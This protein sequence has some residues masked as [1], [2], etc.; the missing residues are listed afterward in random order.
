[1]PEIQVTQSAIEKALANANAATENLTALQTKRNRL[2]TSIATLEAYFDTGACKWKNGGRYTGRPKS[3][4]HDPTSAAAGDCG[5]K[6]NQ[7]F[8][9][10][11]Q[12][13]VIGGQI[14]T[15]EAAVEATRKTHESLVETASRQALL[16][17]EYLANQQRILGEQK[18]TELKTGRYIKVGL[19][20]AGGVIGL[21]AIY[22]IG[23]KQGWF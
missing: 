17:P 3:A 19:I 8:Q 2:M 18:K 14:K 6:K 5:Y 4:G 15:A 9:E 13:G 20:I 16:D 11:G 10:L 7:Y 21:G 23:R 12:R 22:L 1:M